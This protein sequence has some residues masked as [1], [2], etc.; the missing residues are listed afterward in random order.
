LLVA[1]SI[2]LH[3]GNSH[4]TYT[5][6]RPMTVQFKFNF[7]DT[8]GLNS[9]HDT[10]LKELDSAAAEWTKGLKGDGT[11]VVAINEE[12]S[13]DGTESHANFYTGKQADSQGREIFAPRAAFEAHAHSTSDDDPAA[14][15]ISLDLKDLAA[16]PDPVSFLANR[17]G[18]GL[19]FNGWIAD[20]TESGHLASTFDEH[21]HSENGKLV[22]EGQHA[23]QVPL[24]DAH[25]YHLA[26]PGPDLMN[27]HGPGTSVTAL[28]FA[29]LA[30]LGYDIDPS[31]L[32]DSVHDFG[33]LPSG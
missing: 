16:N 4:V 26:V 19:G 17:I 22:F 33:N 20:P 14:L 27:D 2:A 12:T 23:G 31:V 8:P 15:E 25:P 9:A 10:L 28:D 7:D 11:I 32:P 18:I 5:L 1:W 6:E 3:F 13:N 21:V 29:I 24:T 30:D